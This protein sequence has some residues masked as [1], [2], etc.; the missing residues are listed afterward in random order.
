MRR[1]VRTFVR[2]AGRIVELGEQPLLVGRADD[3]ELVLDDDLASR[4]HCRFELR[5][6]RVVVVD[7]DSRN[8]LLVNGLAVRGEQEVHHGD[9]VT[10]GRSQLEVARQ[11]HQPRPQSDELPLA[12]ERGSSAGERTSTGNVFEILAGSADRAL[13]AG[14]PTGA[15]RSAMSLFT[16]VKSHFARGRDVPEGVFDEAVQLALRLAEQ[17]SDPGWL[18]RVLEAHVAARRTMTPDRA[19]RIVALAERVGAPARGLDDYLAL[20]REL[21]GDGEPSARILAALAG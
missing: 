9:L 20:G 3:C 5:G 2:L 16:S 14:D 15:E 10:A 12:V 11:A 1:E 13:A 7:L 8:G 18:E 4:H 6:E 19:R 21:V 17:L